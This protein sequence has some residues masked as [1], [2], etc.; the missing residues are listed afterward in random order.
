MTLGNILAKNSKRPFTICRCFQNQNKSAVPSRG[1]CVGGGGGGRGGCYLHPQTG[2]CVSQFRHQMVWESSAHYIQDAPMNTGTTIYKIHKTEHFVT[3]CQRYL[4]EIFNF[5][6]QNHCITITKHLA[7]E[8]NLYRNDYYS[9]MTGVAVGQ[10]FKIYSH[11]SMQFVHY[12]N[13]PI[14]IHWKF[15]H[16]K[17]KILR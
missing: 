15:Y 17:M 3:I 13:M 14:Q 5:H 1:V 8:T 12:E 6:K 9:Y 16:Q 4:S 10:N 7:E 11:H 2:R